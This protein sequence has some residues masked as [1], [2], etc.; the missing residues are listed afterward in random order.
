MMAMGMVD[1]AMIGR[2]STD[3]IAAVGLGHVYTFGLMIVGLGML[4]AVDPLISQA[5]GAGDERAIGKHVQR[6]VVL[7]CV[8]SVP[9][10]LLAWPA[11]PVLAFFGQPA[12]AA[13]MAE[14]YVHASI[15][16]ILPFLLFMLLRQTLQAFSRTAPVVLAAVLANVVNVFLNWVLIDGNL[17]FPALGATGCAW[18][19]SI[20][21]WLLFGSLLTLGWKELRPHLLPLRREAAAPKPLLRMAHLGLPLGLA[22]AAEY[23][24]FMMTLLLMGRIGPREVAAHQVSITLASFS[25]MFPLGIGAAAAVRVGYA[26]GRSDMA[27]ARRA[28]AIAITAGASIMVVS[29]ALFLLVPEPLAW[30]FTNQREV[31]SVAV[32]LIPVAGVF[33][34]FDGVQAVATGVLRGLGDTR[35]PFKVHLLGFWVLGIPLGCYLAFAAG[36]GPRG[37]WWGL[38]VGLA[39]SA[40]ILLLRVHFRLRGDVARVLID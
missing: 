18:A 32:L 39:V 37:L 23:G 1:I 40:V 34:V 30:L 9:A 31:V 24:A 20:C 3:A 13:G 17:G 8:F 26:V 29:A 22:M 38:V 10:C 21:R 15:P 16:G 4:Q 14:G 27:G 33:Q 25:F 35:T 2:V 28:S 36:A 19:S 6:G 11:G 12:V 5:V 7:A